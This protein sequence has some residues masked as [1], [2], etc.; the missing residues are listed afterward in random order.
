MS[1]LNWKRFALY[2]LIAAAAVLLIV[3][4]RVPIDLARL[5][6]RAATP[7]LLG[8]VLAYVLN[9]L[10]VRYESVWFPHSRARFVV[11][12]RRAVC[13]L[14]SVITLLLILVAVVLLVLPGLRESVE[15][16]VTDLSLALTFLLDWLGQHAD[17]FPSFQDWLVSLENLNWPDLIQKAMDFLA[18]GTTGIFQ[19]TVGI[20]T[21]VANGL[22]TL[23]LGFI[24]ALYLLFGKERLAGQ[25]HRLAAILIRPR[26]RKWLYYVLETLHRSFSSFIVGQCT[27]AVILGLLCMAGMTLFRFPYA[28]MIGALIGFTALIPVAGAYIGAGVGA[29]MIFTV[30]PLKALLFLVFIAVLQQLEG[31]LIYPKVVGSSIGLPGIW[32]LAAVTVGGG[33]LG[34]FGM[35]LAVPLTA[36]A[37]QML[38]ADVVRRSAP[39]AP[40]PPSDGEDGP[41]APPA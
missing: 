20:L 25:F 39:A 7:L 26:A 23:L 17:E 6:L 19:T 37:Y 16:I 12:T 9:L 4:I 34:I 28:S 1:K 18:Q 40:A 10:L 27:E 11:R 2:A 5:A 30:S 33:V 35:L 38:R 24:F 8:C 15:M 13:V 21:A 22:L 31:N 3:Y 32:V 41:G 14:L 36:T 29:F